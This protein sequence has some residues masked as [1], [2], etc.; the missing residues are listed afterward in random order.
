MSVV[1]L[2]K[3]DVAGETGYWMETRMTNARNSVVRWS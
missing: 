1:A 3:E 2:G